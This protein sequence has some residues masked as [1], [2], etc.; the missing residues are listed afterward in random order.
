MRRDIVV[1]VAGDR[2]VTQRVKPQGMEKTA[3]NKRTQYVF[4]VRECQYGVVP[5]DS[6]LMLQIRWNLQQQGGI[7]IST[8]ETYESKILGHEQ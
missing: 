4:K 3:V 8:C 1:S 5:G 6:P 7:K 2:H